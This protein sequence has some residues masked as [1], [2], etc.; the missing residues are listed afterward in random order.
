[1]KNLQLL[2]QVDLTV[3]LF[4]LAKIYSCKNGLFANFLI[5]DHKLRPESTSEAKFVKKF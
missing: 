3:W 5:V 1:M 2:Y 4:F